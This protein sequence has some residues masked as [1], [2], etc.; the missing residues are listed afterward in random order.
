MAHTPF[1]QQWA[2]DSARRSLAAV[3]L[4]RLALDSHAASMAAIKA[5]WPAPDWAAVSAPILA[6]D[7]A[8]LAAGPEVVR[9]ALAVCSVHEQAADE[10]DDPAGAGQWRDAHGTL[11]AR[12]HHAFPAAIPEPFDPAL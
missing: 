7:R 9:A 8:I 3:D 10:T 4:A 12:A 6:L 11:E 5:G 1:T 2:A